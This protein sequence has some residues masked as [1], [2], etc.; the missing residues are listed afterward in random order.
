MKKTVLLLIIHTFLCMFVSGCGN[1]KEF[2]DETPVISLIDV[3]QR[4]ESDVFYVA[5]DRYH[6]DMKQLPVGIFDS[7]IGG[8]TVLSEIVRLDFFNNETI[9][10][11]Y[12]T[13]NYFQTTLR[14]NWKRDV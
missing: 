6:T 4:E 5:F 10:S 8:L 3:V 12:I 1:N 9:T 7:G 11:L 2:T 13:I 14:I